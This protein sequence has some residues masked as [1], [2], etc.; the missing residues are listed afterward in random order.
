MTIPAV[1]P[2]KLGP[3]HQALQKEPL[4]IVH[5]LQRDMYA[6][7][8]STTPNGLHGSTTPELGGSGGSIWGATSR[9]VQLHGSSVPHWT[10][11]HGE[12][13]N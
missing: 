11:G 2:L 9:A 4:P 1:L 6:P 5:V 3:G 13:T 12:G 10:P 8:G 7:S